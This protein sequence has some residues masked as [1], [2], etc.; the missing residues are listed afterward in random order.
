MTRGMWRNVHFDHQVDEEIMG[1]FRSVVDARYPD[2]RINWGYVWESVDGRKL[3]DGSRIDL[4]TDLD[5]SAMRK[6]KDRITRER[7]RS[8]GW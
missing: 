1:I 6:M 8:R 2:G 3:R 7:E 5:S 4:G